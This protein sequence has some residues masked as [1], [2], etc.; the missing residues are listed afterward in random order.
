MKIKT[1]LITLITAFLLAPNTFA[2]NPYGIN[3]E[4]G[5][6]LSENN[7]QIKP[8]MINGLTRLT[9][10][11]GE[12]G[13]EFS[14][15]DKWISNIMIQSPSSCLKRRAALLLGNDQSITEQDNIYWIMRNNKYDIKFSIKRAFVEKSDLLSG[16]QLVSIT[17]DENE[18]NGIGFGYRLYSGSDC[19]NPVANSI[20]IR[21]G[22]QIFVELDI[23]LLKNG[24]PFSSD[25]MFF[26][27][28]DIDANEAIKILNPDNFLSPSNMYAESVEV[29]Q[30]SSGSLK[31]MYV[32]PGERNAF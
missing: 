6:P 5:E 10:T 17:I 28:R 20:D 23:Q 13:I 31:N 2:A 4:G 1:I 8:E 18:S 12:K 14:D 24:E 16:G 26:S 11:K 15:S 9:S 3:Y 22:I 27:I 32:L 30:P 25:E 21:A 19:S 29:L 7:V